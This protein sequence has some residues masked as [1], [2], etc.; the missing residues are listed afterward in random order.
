VK[1]GFAQSSC[2]LP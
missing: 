2:D 1:T